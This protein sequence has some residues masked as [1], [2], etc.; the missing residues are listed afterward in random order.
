MLCPQL[1]LNKKVTPKQENCP[2]KAQCPDEREDYRYQELPIHHNCNCCQSFVYSLT[3]KCDSVTMI[4]SVLL[5]AKTQ[6]ATLRVPSKQQPLLERLP[7][8]RSVPISL[9]KY[10]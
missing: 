6:L 10:P 3:S 2:A 7:P 5:L 1:L 9:L 4:Q 8:V